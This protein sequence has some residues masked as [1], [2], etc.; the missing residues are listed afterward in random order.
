MQDNDMK[1][2]IQEAQPITTHYTPVGA[3]ENCIPQFEETY[4]KSTEYTAFT[5]CRIF[6]LG[7]H[8]DHQLSKIISFAIDKGIHIAYESKMNGVVET[9]SLQFPK[10]TQWH[11]SFV[12]TE[13]QGDWA[14]HL[15]S[16]TIA[17]NTRYP[18][19]T[20]LC[21]ILAL[22]IGGLSSS[23]A[24]IITFLSALCHLNNITLSLA[25]LINILSKV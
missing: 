5:P 10:R 20:V 17:L 7:A 11:V 8:S 25:E 3:S 2:A 24:V 12:P 18:L 19:R 4:C 1:C 16:T 21:A 9:A 23:V 13:K 6:L 15:Q 14:D 22:T